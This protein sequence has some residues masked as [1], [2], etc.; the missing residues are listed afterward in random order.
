MKPVELNPRFTFD[1]FMA[2]TPNRFAL[3]AARRVAERP[4]TMYTPLFIYG[5]AGL[6]KTHLATAI[7]NEVREVFPE[8][9][10]SYR[11]L[12]R[13]IGELT[14]AAGAGDRESLHQRLDEVRLL[15]LDD[16]QILAGRPQF[17]EGLL[18]AWDIVAGNGGQIVLT[19]DRP[20]QEIDDLDDR[21]ISRV[22][23]GLTVD[24][25]VPD[26]ETRLAI[27]RRK[28]EER[29]QTLVAGVAETLARIAFSNVRE[30]EGALNRLI[31]VQELEDRT[32]VADE[33]A[34]LLGRI[35]NPT[36]LD[37]FGS[38]L[39]EITD[40]LDGVVAAPTE[41]GG[42][43]AAGSA[44]D[45]IGG[46]VQGLSGAST[47]TEEGTPGP[48]AGRAAAADDLLAEVVATVVGG[49]AAEAVIERERLD[50]WFLDQEKVVWNWPY[51]GDC[52]VQ[53]WD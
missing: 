35:A 30:L 42:E 25:G 39:A 50:P 6:G 9:P 34:K 31:A 8:S 20:L 27:I 32:I 15:I 19:S 44:P 5:A 33:V 46:A 7:G 41:G 43:E 37:E 53:D 45:Q 23:G 21:L 28:S 18:W 13:F 1:A 49:P 40:T 3:A 29:G 22:S 16:I 38:F 14:T 2:G 11:T 52:I 51:I 36:Q 17:P 24:L 26:Y 48:A 10:V 12:D 47:G 4:G